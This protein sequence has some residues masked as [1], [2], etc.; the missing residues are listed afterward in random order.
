MNVLILSD[1]IVNSGVGQYMCQ[2]AGELHDKGHDVVLASAVI[3]RTDIP[4]SVKVVKLCNGGG[5]KFI[6]IH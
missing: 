2:L 4:T 3:S 5:Q 1:L 6:E